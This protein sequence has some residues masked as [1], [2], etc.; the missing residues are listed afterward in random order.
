[1]VSL[2]I[3]IR[4]AVYATDSDVRA[5]FST[6]TLVDWGHYM[7]VF[8]KRARVRESLDFV[9][10]GSVDADSVQAINDVIQ[11]VFDADLEK[12]LGDY[13]AEQSVKK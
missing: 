7:M 12:I 3:S 11:E 13:I 6:R 1:M 4:E 9:L 10:G 2:G 5:I 8:G